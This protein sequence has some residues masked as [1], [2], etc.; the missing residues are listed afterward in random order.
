MTENNTMQR[1]LPRQER[2]L[3]R[4]KQII[5]SAAA[6]FDEIG[7]ANATPSDIAKA[8]G[9]TRTSLYRYF[10]N[11]ASIIRALA[12]RHLQALELR[13]SAVASDLA[14]E[15]R[16]ELVIEIYAEFYQNEPGYMAVWSGVDSLPELKSIDQ[17]ALDFHSAVIQKQMVS[18]VAG[19][20]NSEQIKM[21]SV[22]LPRT[23]GSILR[24]AVQEPE[25]ADKYV[26]EAK[27]LAKIYL[28]HYADLAGYKLKVNQSDD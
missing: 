22:I 14:L 4:V 5:D 26:Q 18:I 9:L 2:S 13:F 16:I 19:D 28:T 1:N 15:D 7:I 20:L 23:V 24:L 17:S 12:E 3:E 27:V 11:K 10:P 6:L 25:L 21:I 8:S